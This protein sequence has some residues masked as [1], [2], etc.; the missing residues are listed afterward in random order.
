MLPFIILRVP[1]SCVADMRARHACQRN[2]RLH[3]EL[4]VCKQL[5]HHLGTS[6]SYASSRG[7]PANS[8]PSLARICQGLLGRRSCVQSKSCQPKCGTSYLLYCHICCLVPS[9]HTYAPFSAAMQH[10]HQQKPIVAA[11]LHLQ[12]S[13]A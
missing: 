9:G 6:S 1:F 5:V 10:L 11:D 8:K 13:I 7:A 4:L 3:C 12:L 2:L